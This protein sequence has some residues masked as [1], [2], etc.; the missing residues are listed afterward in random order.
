MDTQGRRE[1]FDG[2]C[3]LVDGG[4]HIE[5]DPGEH[6]KGRE[7]RH[8]QLLHHHETGSGTG[9]LSPPYPGIISGCS[10]PFFPCGA[11]FHGVN[12]FVKKPNASAQPLAEPVG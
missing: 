11:T 6:R 4:K 12:G 2:S 5:L 8:A 9:H 3:A 10:R 1:V 7:G